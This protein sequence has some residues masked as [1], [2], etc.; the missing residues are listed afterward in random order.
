M[1]PPERL[2]VTGTDASYLHPPG[3]SLHDELDFLSEAELAPA[4][5]LRMATVNSTGAVPVDSQTLAPSPRVSAP[6]WRR[7]TPIPW[8][9]SSTSTTFMQWSCVGERLISRASPRTD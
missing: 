3:F 4:K 5:I 7:S 2:L 8:P 1:D 9:M 6:I